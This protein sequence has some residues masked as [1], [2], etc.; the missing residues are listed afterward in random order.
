MSQS[1]AGFLSLLSL[2]LLLLSK[3]ILS[4]LRP[5]E[6]GNMSVV[7]KNPRLRVEMHRVLFQP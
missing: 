3:R 4:S 1:D 6:R 5:K 2:L 7:E